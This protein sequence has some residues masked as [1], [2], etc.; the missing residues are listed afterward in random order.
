[1]KTK[2]IYE[3]LL[4]GELLPHPTGDYDKACLKVLICHLRKKLPRGQTIL[5][6]QG[7]GYILE[8]C[9]RWAVCNS[10]YHDAIKRIGLTVDEAAY[11]FG[12]S[13][14]TS[15]RW[16]DGEAHPRAI[17]IVIYLM[18]KYGLKAKDLPW[19]TRPK[20]PMTEVEFYQRF[21]QP[22]VAFTRPSGSQKADEPPVK[23]DE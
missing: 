6:M 14:S 7:K 1:M 18:E 10:W 4:T 15:K 2:V 5:T 9:S 11:W 22:P 19:A 17:F 20:T 23:N 12:V 13:R 16:A 3:H 21:G 8:D